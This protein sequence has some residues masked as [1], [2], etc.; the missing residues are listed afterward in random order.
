[1][2]GGGEASSGFSNVRI[3]TVISKRIFP[4]VW[5]LILSVALVFGPHEIMSTLFFRAGGGELGDSCSSLCLFCLSR[6]WFFGW[7]LELLA[8]PLPLW[9]LQ[10]F[11]YFRFDCKARLDILRSNG[12]C[13]HGRHNI[14]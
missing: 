10:W 7:I 5:L 12:L 11:S 8:L 4:S 1:M 14:C 3:A 13:G 9:F 2:L 6:L